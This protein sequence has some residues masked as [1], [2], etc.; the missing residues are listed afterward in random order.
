MIREFKAKDGRE[1]T[2][3]APKWDDL[4]DML[5]FINALVDEG[6]DIMMDTRQTREQEVDWLAR[7]LTRLEKDEMSVVVA[8]VGGR[9]VGQVEVTKRNMNSKHVGV[10]GIAL[11]DGFREIG[12]GT[13][14][15]KEAENQSRR[16]GLEILNLEVF[17]TNKRAR[18]VNEKV[19]YR[20]VGTWPKAVKRDGAYIDAVMMSKEL[21]E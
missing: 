2:L 3:R 15:M 21:S 9:F 14:L 8:E 7:L 17:G 11:K 20:E 1:V 6:A 19:G 4:D 16:L 5:E 12:I 10:L 18:H 13:E